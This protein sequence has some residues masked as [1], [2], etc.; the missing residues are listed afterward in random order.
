MD[1][2]RSAGP[3]IV[4]ALQQWYGANPYAR[5]YGLYSYA[6]PALGVNWRDCR[7]LGQVSRNLANSV[8]A[9]SGRRNRIEDAGRWWNN[10]NAVTAAIDYMAITRDLS[11]LSPVVENTFAR[12]PAVRR[13]IRSR[14]PWLSGLFSRRKP[15]HYTGFINGYYDDEG[16]W[17]L[18]WIAAYDL[19]GDANYLT[20]AAEIFQ[21]MTIGWDEVWAGGIYWGKYDGAPDRAGVVAVPK[22]WQGPYKNAIANE[23]FIA[24]G[25]ALSLRFRRLNRPAADHPDYLQWALRGW[26]WFS[27]P[28]PQGVAMISEDNLVN[29]SPN[30][31]GVN[32]NTQS[33]WSYNQ[34]VLLG[35]LRDLTELTGDQAYLGWAERIADAFISKPWYAVPKGQKAPP[36]NASGII[37]GILHEHNDCV[38]DG[39]GPARAPGIDT[40]QFKGIFIRNL[41]RLYLSTRKASYRQFILANAES[42]LS[43]L[44]ERHQFGCNWAAPP[45]AADFVRQTAGLD[46]V[47]AAMQVSE[48]NGPE[49]S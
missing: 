25:A 19:T 13:P 40:T 44:N 2:I 34:G 46:L 21:D 22:G 20:A 11:Y 16:W 27:S 28:P 35:G 48:S 42:A 18:A 7:S 1:D 32:D 3:A 15:G 33:V 45:D 24:V 14:Q 4:Q 17:A 12:A 43:H 5:K 30:R 49:R 31:R 6:D 47:N 41:A 9:V 39:S 10:A 36:P 37:G 26:E 29:D 38:P 8:L 23:L